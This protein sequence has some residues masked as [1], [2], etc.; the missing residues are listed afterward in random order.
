MNTGL[1]AYLVA[2]RAEGSNLP[3]FCVTGAGDVAGS[4]ESLASRLDAEQPFFGLQEPLVEA[5]DAPVLSVEDLATRYV[6]VLRTVQPQ[7]PYCLGGWSFGGAVAYEMAQQIH[8]QGHEVALLVLIDTGPTCLPRSALGK[9]YERVRGIAIKIRVR[10]W[11]GASFL[12]ALP[13]VVRDSCIL[14]FP[15]LASGEETLESPPSLKEYLRWVWHDMARQ[16]FLKQAGLSESGDS[17]SRLSLIRHPFVRKISATLSANKEAMYAYVTKPYPGRVTLFRAS[18]DPWG[19]ARRD[20]TLGWKHLAGGGVDV[21]VIPGNHLVIMRKPFVDDLARQLQR[22]LN[23][24]QRK[25][26]AR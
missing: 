5:E 9:A 21:H 12:P 8:A 3:F 23:A 7:G 25:H 2:L 24:V 22:C 4:Y 18:F 1:D 16:F 11:M 15:S 10:L 20:T 6:E 19:Q 13:S 17:R 14:A 26:A